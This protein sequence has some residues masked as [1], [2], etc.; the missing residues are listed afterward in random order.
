M[1]DDSSEPREPEPEI[2]T[3]QWPD[4]PAAPSP[5]EVDLIT[6]AEDPGLDIKTS[7]NEGKRKE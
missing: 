1:N 3:S 6:D 2:P 5:G 4:H 7:I